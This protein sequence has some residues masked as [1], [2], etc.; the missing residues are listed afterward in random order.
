MGGQ[1][2]PN[3]SNQSG[4]RLKAV[5]LFD[6]RSRHPSHRVVE[7]EQFFAQ[8]QAA[9]RLARAWRKRVQARA[10]LRSRRTL[11]RNHHVIPP[12]RLSNFQ[13]ALWGAHYLCLVCGKPAPGEEF[14]CSACPAVGHWSCMPEKVF[15]N[16][17]STDPQQSVLCPM[18]LEDES[19]G[20][21]DYTVERDRLW[22]KYVG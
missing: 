15:P 1:V 13:H 21:A 2:S 20:R 22:R 11:L 12:A 7:Q 3:V 17:G 18:C 16:C 14:L 10:N 6:Q 5:D 8:Y 4:N 19:A 9:I